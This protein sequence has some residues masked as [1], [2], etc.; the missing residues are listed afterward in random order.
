MEDS[1]DDSIFTSSNGANSPPK[2]ASAAPSPL[3]IGVPLDNPEVTATIENA[4]ITSSPSQVPCNPAVAAGA[5]A[6]NAQKK[7]KKKSSS[8]PSVPLP[9]SIELPNKTETSKE[10]ASKPFDEHGDDVPSDV[11]FGLDD[12]EDYSNLIVVPPTPIG[13][14]CTTGTST[15][16]QSVQISSPRVP[17][18]EVDPPKADEKGMETEKL[19]ASPTKTSSQTP[20]QSIQRTATTIVVT[21]SVKSSTSQIT[22][23]TQASPPSPNEDFMEAYSHASPHDDVEDTGANKRLFYSYNSNSNNLD[24]DTFLEEGMHEKPFIVKRLDY[25]VDPSD[26]EGHDSTKQSDFAQRNHRR[27][28]MRCFWCSMLMIAA[29]AGVAIYMF[30]FKNGGMRSSAAAK[31]PVPTMAPTMEPTAPTVSPAPSF[32]PSLSAVPSEMPSFLP[33]VS[34]TQMPSRSPSESPSDAPSGVPTDAPTRDFSS[35]LQDYLFGSFGITFED[36]Q[37][38]A[39]MA[40]EWLNQEAQQTIRGGTMD[41]TSDVAQRFALLTLEFSAASA[42]EQGSGAMM[43]SGS[44]SSN[45]LNTTNSSESSEPGASVSVRQV[46]LPTGIRNSQFFVHQC[47]WTGIQCNDDNHVTQL[48]WDYRDYRGTIPTE[49]RL[50]SNL[51]LLDLSN[52]FLESTIPEELYSLTNLEQLY[53]FKNYLTGTI[54]T[55]IGRLSKIKHI[56]LSHNELTGPIPTEL[57]SDG[58]SEN[59]IRPLLYFNV[60]SNKLTGTIPENLRLRNLQYFDVGRNRLTGRLPRDLG[61][62]FVELRQLHLDHNDFRGTLPP[63]YNGV[64]NHRLEAFTVDH[65]RLTGYVYGER[66]LYNKLVHYTL[67][68]NRF[69]GLARENCRMEIPYGEMVEFKADCDVCRCYGYFRLCGL[70]C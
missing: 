5:A 16:S 38:P 59:G 12:V 61:D 3:S 34:P 13:N 49:I 8:R 45:L 70:Y 42:V 11:S 17:S 40:V 66:T 48:R 54:S 53:L 35:A 60:Y 36:P 1:V 30:V 43:A 68:E 37:S 56:H 62:T 25:D 69:S 21:P 52:N 33:S 15:V 6:G 44:A 22:P 28:F 23:E 65:N 19:L 31:G 18:D 55:R 46:I 47:N 7:K 64:G 24:E 9:P 29:A 20:D 67:H 27:C 57:K 4:V 50:L 51:K 26:D 39:T 14:S 32:A 41:M 63:N 10:N 58:S 2:R